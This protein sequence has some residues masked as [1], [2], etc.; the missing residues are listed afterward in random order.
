MQ[1]M[2]T[3][4][5]ASC[6]IALKEWASVV[7]ACASGE[8]LVL[9]RKGGLIE[10]ASGFAFSS[11]AFLFYP[12]FEHQTVSFLRSPHTRYFDEALARK[13]SDGQVHLELVGSVAWSTRIL[14]PALIKRLE[15][16]HVYN[17]DFLTQRL[18]WQPD[19]PLAVAVVR[20]FRLAA[21]TRLPVVSRYAGC[22]S[23]VELEQAVCLEGATPVLDDQAFAERC[24]RIQAI[25]DKSEAATPIPPP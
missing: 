2:A 6:Q 21:P 4:L 14:E 20:A 1:T 7:Q 19:Q 12:T 5:P 13:P 3:S 10:P 22:K 24:S 8:Q 23:W 17:D 11:T 25:L 16:F 9:I 15:P 18:R